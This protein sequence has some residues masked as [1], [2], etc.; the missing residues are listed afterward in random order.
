MI[1]EAKKEQRLG[2]P[3]V[4][5]V[6]LGQGLEDG[7]HLLCHSCQGKFKL[8]LG[9]GSGR[10]EGHRE[11]WPLLLSQGA[12]G[13]GSWGGHLGEGESSWGRHTS[14]L[15]LVSLGKGDS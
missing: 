6:S 12:F 8:V 1:T 5:G 15:L 9:K 13:S 3:W 11:A 10:K 7:I 4:P 2:C 14:R